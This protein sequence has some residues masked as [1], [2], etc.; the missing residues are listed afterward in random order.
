[1]SKQENFFKKKIAIYS[2]KVS[3]VAYIKLLLIEIKT[4]SQQDLKSNIIYSLSG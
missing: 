4:W 3:T 2:K 1:M